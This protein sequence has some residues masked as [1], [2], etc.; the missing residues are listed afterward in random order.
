MMNLGLSSSAGNIVVQ[1]VMSGSMT[2]MWSMVNAQQII[3]SYQL[4][5][6]PMPANVILVMT[7][8]AN[9]CNFDIF[10]TER[11][12]VFFFN[13]T[14]TDSP[15]VG[16]SAMGN[17]NKSLI[18]YQ[19]SAFLVMILISFNTCSTVLSIRAGTMTK[20]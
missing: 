13:F 15:G 17:D 14:Q 4:L 16:F 18:L 7:N 5:N 19:G 2:Q 6:L 3:L 1:I 10:P 9:I 8:L 11:I 12:L 20:F